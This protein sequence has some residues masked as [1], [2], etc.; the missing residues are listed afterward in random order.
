MKYPLHSWLVWYLGVM[1][2]TGTLVNIKGYIWYCVWWQ[3][4]HHYHN[5]SI[6]VGPISLSHITI[7]FCSKRCCNLGGCW[8]T[9]AMLHPCGLQDFADQSRLT[10]LKS[11]IIQ[12]L[13]INDQELSHWFSLSVFPIIF[14]TIFLER[15]LYIINIRLLTCSKETIIHVYHKNHSI[16]HEQAGI[17]LAR[18]KTTL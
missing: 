3:I 5:I 18:H 17:K 15:I 8:Q 11:T 10:K 2:K 9:T 6:W 7:C 14:E 4:H 16:R 12:C 1:C 13:Y